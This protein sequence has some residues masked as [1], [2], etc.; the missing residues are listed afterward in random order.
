METAQSIMD[1]VIN[2]LQKI[3]VASVPEMRMMINAIEILERL[4]GMMKVEI[5]EE[6][7][8]SDENQGE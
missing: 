6:V 1:K 5:V 7:T 2:N 4:K 3:H 8:E